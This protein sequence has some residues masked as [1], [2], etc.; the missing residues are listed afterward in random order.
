MAIKTWIKDNFSLTYSEG[1]IT[2]HKEYLIKDFSDVMY[3]Y[4]NINIEFD[5]KNVFKHRCCEIP[6][7]QDLSS[8]IKSLVKTK[9]KEMFKYYEKRIKN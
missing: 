5:K 2:P 8:L 6:K 9:Q 1:S 3:F 4:Y 7:V